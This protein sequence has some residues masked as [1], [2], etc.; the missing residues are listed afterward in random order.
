MGITSRLSGRSILVTEDEILIALEL[1]ELFEAQGAKVSIASTPA[2]ALHLVE[3]LVFSAAVLDCGPG[4]SNDAEL[5]RALGVYGV[6]FMFYTGYDDLDGRP[7]G[8]PVVTKPASGL[9]LVDTVIQL[10]NVPTHVT[11]RGLPSNA[12]N[13]PDIFE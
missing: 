7:S 4:E 9:V 3:Q 8:A 10:L 13:T 5:C 2:H 6:P 1:S 12:E 11:S